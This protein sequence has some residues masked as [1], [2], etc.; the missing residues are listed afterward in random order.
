MISCHGIKKYEPFKMFKVATLLMGN[1]TTIMLRKPKGNDFFDFLLN[2]I[3]MVH[4]G[5]QMCRTK[6]S[7]FQKM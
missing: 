4:N 1:L 3:C 6:A 7:L 5:H 2:L